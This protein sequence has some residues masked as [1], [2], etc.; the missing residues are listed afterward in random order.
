MIRCYRHGSPS[1]QNRTSSQQSQVWSRDMVAPKLAMS[2]P[3][4]VSDLDRF[5]ASW[6]LLWIPQFM[7]IQ[8]SLQF[9]ST[10]NDR[11][12]LFVDQFHVTVTLFKRIRSGF[13]VHPTASGVLPGFLPWRLLRGQVR[14][15]AWP[16]GLTVTVSRPIKNNDS[17]PSSFGP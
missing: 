12:Y 3:P 6:Q 17:I 5:S 14:S 13:T 7:T 10:H 4:S 8:Q 11:Q 2:P 15:F 16:V 9:G 1:M